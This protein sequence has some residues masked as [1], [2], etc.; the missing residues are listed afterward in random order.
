MVVQKKVILDV[1]TPVLG[2]VVVEGT[3]LINAS[4]HVNLSAV[5]LEIKGG[6]LI[7]ATVDATGEQVLGPFTGRTTLTMHGTNDKLSILHGSADPRETPE[8]VL[9]LKVFQWDLQ[10]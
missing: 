4:S 7:I 10:P 2:R 5:W 3:L 1:S 6:K 9:V 8:V